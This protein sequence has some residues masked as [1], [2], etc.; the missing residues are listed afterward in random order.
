MT[1]AMLELPVGRGRMMDRRVVTL[2][3]VVEVV[4]V[5]VNV[6]IVHLFRCFSFLCAL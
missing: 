5:V 2:V 3:E 4:V 6:V 1:E